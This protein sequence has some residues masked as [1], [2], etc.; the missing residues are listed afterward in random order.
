MWNTFREPTLGQRE[1]K[2]SSK[3]LISGT[4]TCCLRGKSKVPKNHRMSIKTVCICKSNILWL[5]WFQKRDIS[6]AKG[7]IKGLWGQRVELMVVEGVACFF[8]IYT[9]FQELYISIFFNLYNVSLRK[10]FSFQSPISKS[11]WFKWLVY[12]ITQ[13]QNWIDTQNSCPE[14]ALLPYPTSVLLSRGRLLNGSGDWGQCFPGRAGSALKQWKG[15]LL[16]SPPHPSQ[17]IRISALNHPVPLPLPFPVITRKTGEEGRGN[18]LWLSWA[19]L[20]LGSLYFHNLPFPYQ[21]IHFTSE[22][23]LHTKNG[24]CLWG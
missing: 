6:V 3:P 21:T 19:L 4:F 18:C 9:I 24:A 20:L 1:E 11:Q 15:S 22:C 2:Q 5:V 7:G 13:E 17:I 10:N 14:S 16:P 12:K 23:L 8:V